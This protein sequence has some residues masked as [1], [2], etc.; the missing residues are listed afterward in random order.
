[1]FDRPGRQQACPRRDGGDIHDDLAGGDQLLGEQIAEPASGLDRPGAGLE[2]LGPRHQLVDLA[3]TGSD[4][5][6][7]QLLLAPVDRDGRVGRLGR[8]DTDDH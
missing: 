8:V 3:A 5:L 4:L 2:R 1:L 7:G 6:A